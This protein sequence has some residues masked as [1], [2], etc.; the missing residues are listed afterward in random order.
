MFKAIGFGSNLLQVWALFLVIEMHQTMGDATGLC[1]STD[2][3]GHCASRPSSG[4]MIIQQLREADFTVAIET[5]LA[6]HPYIAAAVAGFL[7]L[8]QRRAFVAEQY[9]VQLHKGTSFAALAGQSSFRPHR[10]ADLPPPSPVLPGSGGRP[11]L[12]QF[13]VEGLDEA[14]LAAYYNKSSSPLAQSYPSYWARLALGQK[15]AAGAAAIAVNFPAWGSMCAR[16]AAALASHAEYGY[17]GPEDPALAFVNFFAT[18]LEGLDD[19]AAA[20][21]EEEGASL[22]DVEGAVRLLQEYE[23]LLWDAIFQASAEQFSI[24]VLSRGD[25]VIRSESQCRTTEIK[26]AS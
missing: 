24:V 14:T 20:I 17:A 15:R 9:A 19:M 23:F 16:L 8:P 1:K 25:L 3:N 22:A 12:F 26:C 5:K 10:L 21:I 11:D 13:V 2:Q 6:T 7:T 4:R 18:P